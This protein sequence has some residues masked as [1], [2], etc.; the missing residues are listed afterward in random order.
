MTGPR[1]AAALLLF[2]LSSLAGSAGRV[3]LQ[4]PLPDPARL[5]RDVRA[6][7]RFDYELLEQFTYVEQRRDIRISKL[8]KVTVGPMRTFEVHPSAQP[9]RTWKRLVAVDGKPLDPVELARRDAEHERHVREQAERQARETPARRARR[10]EEEA[11]ARREREAIV[12]DAFAV[13]RPTVVGRET[14]EGQTVLSIA[15]T[16]RPDARVTTREGR[17]MKQFEGRVWIA[18]DDNQVAGLELQ[19]IDDVTIGWGVVGRVHEGSRFVFRRR[20]I[21]DTWLPAEVRFQGTGRT[22]LFRTFEIEAVTSYSNY[23]RKGSD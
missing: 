8:G 6:A 1:G 11:E 3:A 2:V 18:E 20:K 21:E 19:A 9:G 10:L 16:P 14:L 4:S 15:L 12:D 23:R 13:Y 5:M 22:L 17:W 7:A